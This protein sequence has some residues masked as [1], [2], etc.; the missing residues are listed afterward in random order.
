MLGARLRAFINHPAGPKT[1]HFWGP[2]ANWG[3]V[4]AV[5]GM[6]GNQRRKMKKETRLIDCMNLWTMQRPWPI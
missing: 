6:I 4:A 3:F 5:C 1:T 2:I